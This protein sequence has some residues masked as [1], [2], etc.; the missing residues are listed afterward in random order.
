MVKSTDEQILYDLGKRGLGYDAF[1]EKYEM[2]KK[3]TKAHIAELKKKGYNITTLV[4][5]SEAIFKLQKYVSEKTSLTQLEIDE[6]FSFGL[7]SDTHLCARTCRLEALCEYYDEIERRGIHNVDHC[8]DLTD[9]IGVYPGQ[10]VELN[11]HT[12]D[13]QVEFTVK[14]YPKKKD[15]KTYF[16][17]G[18]HDLKVL[19]KVGI[20]VGNIISSKRDDLIYLGQV[21]ANLDIGGIKIE[22]SHYE[23]S[24]PYA[25]SYRSQ[26]Y[27]RDYIGKAPDILGLGHAHKNG[28][29]KVQNTFCFESGAWQSPNNFTKSKG[30]WGSIGGWIIN[31]KQK[32]GVI[33]SIIPEWLEF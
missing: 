24:M 7:I 10:E 21:M 14:N 19:K 29:F 18:N 31:I 20:D 3:A 27:L 4:V 12:L 2:D 22:L 9:G 11:Q 25:T 13:E 5:D 30:L 26:K 1:L 6:E 33:N 15:V 17:T 8:G 16:V 32:D 28:F 23:G